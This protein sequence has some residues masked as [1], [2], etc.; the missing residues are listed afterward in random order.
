MLVLYSIVGISVIL[1]LIGFVYKSNPNV[2]VGPPPNTV[3]ITYNYAEFVVPNMSTN[4][5]CKS[6]YLSNDTDYHVIAFEPLKDNQEM[7]HHMILYETTDYF[8]DEYFDCASMP[9][10]SSPLY[11]WAVGGQ[12]S[13]MPPNVGIRI[14][15][16][17]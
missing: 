8:G 3:D 10:G 7:L 4:Y 5:I 16:S 17:A 13:I 6:F 12:K 11:T 2:V 1:L 9:K 15:K 14:G